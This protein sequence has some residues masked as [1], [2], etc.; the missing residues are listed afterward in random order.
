MFSPDGS[1]TM[2]LQ[3]HYGPISVVPTAELRRFLD[4]EATS[5]ERVTAPPS[6]GT[7][8]R[9]IDHIRWVNARELEFRATCCGT[10]E[11]VTKR[12]GDARAPQ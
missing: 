9:V 11:V 2:L 5:V 10:S 3:S 7:A 12:I 8:A 1:Y 4:G 6:G